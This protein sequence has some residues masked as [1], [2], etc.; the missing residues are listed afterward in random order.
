MLQNIRNKQTTTFT[1]AASG[2]IS[3]LVRASGALTRLVF[4]VRVTPS[5]SYASNHA[6]DGLWRVINTLA[7]KGTG[8]THY[9]SMGDQ[10]IGRMLHLLNRWDGIVKGAGHEPLGTPVDV[11]WVMHFGSRP[12]DQFGRPNPFDLSAFVPA[13]D[14]RDL[15]FEWGTTANT[16]TDAAITISSAVGH[17][18]VYEVLGTAA[19]LKQEMARQGIFQPMIPTSSYKSYAHT[20]NFSD[21]SSEHDTPSGAFLRRIALL[22]QDEAAPA[23]GT[24][25]RANDEV[26]QVGLK[27]PIGNQRVFQDDFRA[28]A[29]SDGGAID[30]LAEIDVGVTTG[31]IRTSGGFAVMDLRQHGHTDYGLDLRPF[32]SGDVKLG[33]TIENYASGDDTFIWWDQV[34]PYQF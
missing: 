32:K 31:V 13:F 15:T 22:V 26:A 10:E 21:L 20:A 4:R 24:N 5:A 17:L 3:Q 16:V 23:T 7:L 28:M 29:H 1:W 2:T 11:V 30:D 8:G 33:L 19:E 6:I 14:D 27:L 34:R 25:L 18:T 9:L 12:F